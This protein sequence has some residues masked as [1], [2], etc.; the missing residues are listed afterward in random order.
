MGE[1][2]RQSTKGAIYIGIGV[3]LGFVINALIFPRIL[4]ANQI[5]LISIL[6]SYSS[7][8]AQFASL[9]TNNVISKMFPWFR[10]VKNKHNGFLFLMLI[11]G[12]IGFIL[13]C[14]VFWGIKPFLI[15][16][17]ISKSPLLVEYIYL[18][19]PFTL[20]LLLFGILDNYYKMLY[21]SVRGALLKE[22]GQRFLILLSVI[23]L[24]YGMVNFKGF[25]YLYTIS[26]ALPVLLLIFS[27][28]TSKH[29]F[30]QPN[31]KFLSP[32]LNKTMIKVG[33][34]GILTGGTNIIS[35]HID[36]IMIDDALGLA[37]TGIYTTV[38]FFATLV[39]LPS[40]SVI[41]ASTV[42]IADSWKNNDVKLIDTIYKKTCLTQFII[43]LLILIG[44]WVNIDNIFEILPKEFEVGKYVILY[45]GIA[46]LL[47]MISGV[48]TIIIGTSPY[49]KVQ[50]LLKVIL[51]ILL[52]VSNLIFIPKYGITG[53]AI[54]TVLSK[55]IMH[56]IKHIFLW[57]KYGMQPYNYLFII[58][59]AIG[60]A[61]YFAGYLIPKI[62]N[63]I[64][65]IVIRSSA[66][67]LTFGT[68]I[69]AFKISDDINKMFYKYLRLIKNMI[70]KK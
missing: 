21:N 32:E 2:Q 68:L 30:L 64:L 40:R 6:I 46:F 15:A 37:P 9:G 44:L 20:F 3:L 63:Y 34:F 54:A 16:K 42:Y 35:L 17:S 69:L 61:S 8:F 50:T 29:L 43:G 45:V 19:L 38:F 52:I 56:L 31:W 62:D 53:A 49:Y 36:R 70:S 41:K 4:E 59:L 24:Y 26:L 22:V 7:L 39:R 10:D 11:V 23:I 67:L 48:S 28:K 33:L 25:I 47:D 18:L 27:I 14:I 12:A 5:G 13:T 66:T 57:L 58:I 60:S 1:I 65:D 51:I 55:L